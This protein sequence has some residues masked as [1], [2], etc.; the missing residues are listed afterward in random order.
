M[1]DLLG[2]LRDEAG[3]VRYERVGVRIGDS[4]SGYLEV[5]D[6]CGVIA[7]QT[8]RLALEDGRAGEVHVK[9]LQMGE[10][11]TIRVLF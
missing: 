11:G 3:R 8:Y 6:A 1:R 9:G 4:W 5:A 10:G 7:G 2:M